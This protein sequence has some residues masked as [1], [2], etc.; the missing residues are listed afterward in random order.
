LTAPPA[1]LA[2]LPP[3][4][5]GKT[6]WPWTT[7][8]PRLPDRMPDGRAWPRISIVTPS[9]NQ[10]EFLEETLRSVLLQG[11]P[12]LEY[13]VMDGASTDQSVAIIERYAPW[14]SHWSSAPDKGQNDAIGRG[15]DQSTGA[16]LNWLNSDDQ[17]CAHALTHVATCDAMS[18]G[19]DLICGV[20]ILRDSATGLERL[21]FHWPTKWQ[22]F[23]AGA[24]DFPQE[25]TFF[26][27]HVWEAAGG[28]DMRLRNSFDVALYARAL[29]LARRVAFS[30]AAMG[31]MN[32]H[33]EQKTEVWE[34]HKLAER[35]ILDREYAPKD[36]VFRILSRAMR[37]RRHRFARA[38]L[39]LLILGDD[40]FVVV[41]HD[42]HRGGWQAYTL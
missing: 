39:N 25:C 30:P 24:P 36:L 28:L 42:P 16:I 18:G 1:S 13:I 22:L 3:P 21:Q 37:T 31:I 35:E 2:T 12:D 23:A 29:K 32:L 33:P 8:T 34:D 4:P 5:A 20:R 11:Y 17:L 10:G 15:L 7:E 14:L 6:G 40:R 41:D 38:I 26:S 9:Y 27:R 19:A